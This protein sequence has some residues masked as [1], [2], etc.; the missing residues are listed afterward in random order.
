M[1]E[2]IFLTIILVK[3]IDIADDITQ[4]KLLLKIANK[5]PLK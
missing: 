3:V 5:N 4:V 1:I 2:I